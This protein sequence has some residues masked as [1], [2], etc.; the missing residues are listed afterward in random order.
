LNLALTTLLAAVALL[1]LLWLF[2]QEKDR[3]YA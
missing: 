1:S 3:G 2:K